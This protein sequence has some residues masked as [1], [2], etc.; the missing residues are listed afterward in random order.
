MLGSEMTAE[1]FFFRKIIGEDFKKTTWTSTITLY[2]L[3]VSIFNNNGHNDLLHASKMF[4]QNSYY[5]S[6]ECKLHSFSNI[7]KIFPPH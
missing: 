3:L 1:M 7:L 4:S 2:L 6:K 5:E